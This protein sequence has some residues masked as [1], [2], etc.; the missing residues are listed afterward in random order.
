MN[1]EDAVNVS[2]ITLKRKVFKCYPNNG[3]LIKVIDNKEDLEEVRGFWEKIQWHPYTEI[4]YYLKFSNLEENFVK[5]HL[6]VL[7]T[8]GQPSTLMVGNVLNSQIN[9]KIGYKTIWNSKARCLEIVYG[10]IL[11]SP[12]YPDCLLLVKELIQCLIR[13][14]IDIVFLNH[15]RIDSPIYRIAKK[16]PNTFCRDQFT[17]ENPHRRLFL[18][19]SFE[20]F[21]QQR[22]RNTK[23]N[24]RKYRNRIT[25]QFGD[26]LSIKCYTDKDEIDRIMRDIES[27]AVKTYQRGL[28]V[29]F[30]NNQDT[31][32]K[33]IYAADQNWLRAYVLYI[34]D[35]PCAFCVAANII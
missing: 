16:L 23:E 10:G 24:I 3:N 29:G 7:S 1:T 28:G 27:I 9:W 22:S 8:N 33:W 11:G 13:E 15:L 14:K 34:K 20:Q 31:R 30:F 35:S 2:E 25:K 18:P 17:F 5:P 6:I 19:N 12:S 26:D 21:Y 32:R 4:D